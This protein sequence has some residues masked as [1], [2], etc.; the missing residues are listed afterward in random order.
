M[1]EESETTFYPDCVGKTIKEI[2]IESI[3]ATGNGG[4]NYDRMTVTFT[5][6]T[7]RQWFSSDAS[8]YQ[9]GIQ[10][11]ASRYNNK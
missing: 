11:G 3:W 1:I 4:E 10:D 9:S 5:D 8:G 2:K 7:S 6:G